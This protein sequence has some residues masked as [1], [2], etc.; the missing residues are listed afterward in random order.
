MKG[1][2]SFDPSLRHFN[3]NFCNL[4]INIEAKFLA[5]TFSF[6]LLMYV[7]VMTG[8]SLCCCVVCCVSQ[9]TPALCSETSCC[10]AASTFPDTG[11]VSMPTSSA[12]TSRCG[13]VTLSRLSHHLQRVLGFTPGPLRHHIQSIL[14]EYISSHPLLETV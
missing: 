8:L 14:H 3:T 9:C 7:C 10:R 1:H 2:V 13:P 12:K 11:C 4:S 5:K 6:N